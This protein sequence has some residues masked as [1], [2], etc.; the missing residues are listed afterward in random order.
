MRLVEEILYIHILCI[1]YTCTLL[2]SMF[3]YK[4]AIYGFDW[5]DLLVRLNLK[6]TKVD[7]ASSAISPSLLLHSARH[8]S[9]TPNER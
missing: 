1:V 6:G 2:Y 7:N 8:I 4:V 5:L 9:H 3:Y